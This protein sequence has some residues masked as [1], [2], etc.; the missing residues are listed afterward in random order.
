MYSQIK[1]YNKQGKL[2]ENT[3]GAAVSKYT[4]YLDGLYY[5]EEELNVSGEVLNDSISN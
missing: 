4:P 3:S 5:L 1:R 2:A